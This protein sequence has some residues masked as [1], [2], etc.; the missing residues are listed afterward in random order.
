MKC[1]VKGKR[2]SCV[3]C[4]TADAY[5]PL[6]KDTEGTGNNGVGLLEDITEE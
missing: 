5:Q 3:Y 1:F 6:Q 4:I 2:N